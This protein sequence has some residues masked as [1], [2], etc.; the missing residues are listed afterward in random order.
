MNLFTSFIFNYLFIFIYFCVFLF[1]FSF[2]FILILY[3]KFPFLNE[4]FFILHDKTC[5][6]KRIESLNSNG[7]QFFLEINF[8]CWMNFNN[9]QINWP[10]SQRIKN[11][12]LLKRCNQLR[13]L[14]VQSPFFISRIEITRL[15][16][17]IACI[18]HS[19]ITT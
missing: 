10:F 17:T 6:R 11:R 8:F 14:K 3:I 9:K 12:L 5:F 1:T 13:T 18:L 2:F 16:I 4:S 19:V 7:F 15:L